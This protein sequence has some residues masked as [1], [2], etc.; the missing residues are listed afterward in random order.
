MAAA[1]D[2]MLVRRMS[3]AMQRILDLLSTNL[4]LKSK[5]YKFKVQAVVNEGAFALQT[6]R[7]RL[8]PA[9]GDIAPNV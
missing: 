8:L 4:V 1:G 3:S 5:G 7:L 9:F 6:M 2:P